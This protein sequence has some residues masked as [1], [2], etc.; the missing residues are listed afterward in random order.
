VRE[1]Y[2]KRVAEEQAARRTLFRRLAIDEIALRTDAGIVEP[3][4]QFF[5]RRET[6]LQVGRARRH[7]A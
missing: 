4:M 3:L 7:L 1:R 2:E 5:R 6:R